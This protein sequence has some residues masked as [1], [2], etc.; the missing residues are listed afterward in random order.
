[1]YLAANAPFRNE[2]TDIG[3]FY[4]RNK[5]GRML[6]LSALVETKPMSGPEFT[7]RFNL[8]RSAEITGTAAADYSSGQ[9]MDAME[10]VAK[11]VL[12]REY[13]YSWNALS[14]Q[15]KNAPSPTPTF[16]LAVLLVFL[17]LA[18]QYES[19]SLPMS[20]LLGTPVALVG[21]FA[22]LTLA[23]MELNVYGQ[24]GLVML[25]GLSAKNAILIVEFA[26]VELERGASPVDAALTAAR[27]R[28][29][30]ILMTA[31][32]FILGCAPLLHASGAGGVSRK[33]LGTAV[34]C[35]SLAATLLG[36]FLTPALFV[37]IERIANRK[38]RDQKREARAGEV[39]P[40]QPPGDQ[41]REV[42]V[43]DLPP[44]DSPSS[45]SA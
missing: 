35:G 2:A 45:L 43:E 22:G 23:K 3:R 21:A 9:A 12:P 7:N 15:Q 20:V 6:P 5:A 33:T 14:Y 37:L 24:I 39:P 13:G 28:L 25:L 16:V 40:S 8:Y 36:V 17:I 19:W 34:V 30:P 44:S 38:K 42:L 10:E 1:M 32:A 31:F 26:K 11:E 18:A 41:E 4:V 27:L 29:R